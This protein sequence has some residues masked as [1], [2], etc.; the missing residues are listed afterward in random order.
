MILI[1][2][3]FWLNLDSGTNKTLWVIDNSLSMVV[4]DITTE[5]G[6]MISRLDFAK[7]IINRHSSL[8]EW[9][10]A[11]MSSAYGAKLEIPMTDNHAT[12]LDIL[13]GIS[14]IANG[15][16]SILAHPIDTIRLLY[17][18]I[19]NLHII[20]IT[21]GEFSDSGSTLSGFLSVPSIL[22]V[23]VGTRS[24]WPILEWYNN[25][26]Y[27]RYKESAWQKVNSIRDDLRLQSISSS[28]WA[29]LILLDSEKSIDMSVLF[30]NT[31]TDY[32]YLYFTG[33]GILCILFWLMLPRYHYYFKKN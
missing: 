11:I 16:G 6:V 7:Q 15:G 18:N 2:I 9:E 26:W 5:S 23:W 25:D 33:M 1:W 31:H 17:G 4:T 20:W 19:R 22:F 14:P 12:F 10:Q 3:G 27:P 21:D 30:K 13:Q 8:I 29:S 28:L 24:W 32:W